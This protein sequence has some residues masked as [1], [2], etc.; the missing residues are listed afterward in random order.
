MLYPTYTV[1]G[2]AMQ[3]AGG[4][5]HEHSEMQILPVHPG[6]QA[7][8]LNIAGVNGEI[9]LPSTNL[10]AQDFVLDMVVNAVGSDGKIPG[11]IAENDA[12]LF[13]NTQELLRYFRISRMTQGGGAIIQRKI[14]ASTTHTAI[15]FLIAA[16]EVDREAY[17][18]WARIKYVFRIPSGLWRGRKVRQKTTILD[19][20][21]ET[22][23][24][25]ATSTA[26]I[27]DAKV[28]LTGP[29]EIIRVMNQY[30]NGFEL[31]PEENFVA[32]EAVTVDCKTWDVS[33]K[34][35]VEVGDTDIKP[36]TT[37]YSSSSM[38]HQVGNSSASALA[39]MPDLVGAYVLT[40]GEARVAGQT[41][42]IIDTAEAFL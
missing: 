8:T 17:S 36:P 21:L 26:P 30:G 29:F 42:I 39:L 18:D 41:S 27:T 13:H 31:K 37:G 7:H 5:W 35:S 22:M 28:T 9:M 14:D 15:G 23:R 16:A 6:M 32:G 40:T 3:D 11:N 38:I 2:T 34:F 1:N 24:G 33:K 10:E 25:L 12:N 4:R 19:G 20:S